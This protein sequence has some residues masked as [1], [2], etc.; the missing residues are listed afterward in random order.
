MPSIYISGVEK[1]ILSPPNTN[2][3]KRNIGSSI[4]DF[5]DDKKRNCHSRESGNPGL[6]DS[7]FPI[8]L[9]MTNYF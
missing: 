4:K 7:G 9:G 5:E 1:R 8:K 6:K 3:V 2:K